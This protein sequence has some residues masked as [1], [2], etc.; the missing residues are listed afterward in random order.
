MMQ[1]TDDYHASF[2]YFLALSIELSVRF[3]GLQGEWQMAASQQILRVGL[4]SKALT[5]CRYFGM[6]DEEMTCRDL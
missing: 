3:D 6:E 5:Y 1:F 4:P 2:T